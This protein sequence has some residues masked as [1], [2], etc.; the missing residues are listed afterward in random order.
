MSRR[1]PTL[2]CCGDLRSTAVTQR[3]NG[4]LGLCDVDDDDDKVVD[5]IARCM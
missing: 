2:Y 3:R 4:P 5:V 1:M